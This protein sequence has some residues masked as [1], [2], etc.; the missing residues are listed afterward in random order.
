MKRSGFCA[1]LLS[2]VFAVGGCSQET[3]REAGEALD[4]TGEAL[5]SA[6]ED[7]ANVTGGAIEGAE[8]AIDENEAEPDTEAPE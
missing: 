3:Q 5:D 6:A 1:V 4:E 7:A 2:L 8:E